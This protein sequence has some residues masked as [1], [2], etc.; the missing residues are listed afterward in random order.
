VHF[1][2]VWQQNGGRFGVQANVQADRPVLPFLIYAGRGGERV[3]I[4]P[5]YYEWT[6]WAAHASSD[7]SARLYFSGQVN[8]GGFYDGDRVQINA[9]L[10]AQSKGRFQSSIGILRND[11]NLPYGDFVSDLVRFR[12]NYSFTPR[13][14]LQALVQYNSQTEAL[15]SNVRFAWLSR[16]G[17]GFFIVYNEGRDTYDQRPGEAVLGRTLIVKYTRQFDF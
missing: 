8:W 17:T 7:P 9:E 16:S 2:E 11:V 1:F 5:G 3:V 13:V 6:E 4:P 10:G 14:S 12:A 15:S